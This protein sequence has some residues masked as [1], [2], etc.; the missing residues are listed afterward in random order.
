MLPPQLREPVRNSLEP[1]ASTLRVKL[2]SGRAIPPRRFGGIMARIAAC[3][4][5]AAAV[6]AATVAALKRSW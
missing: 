3:E 1:E 2:A 4:A 6:L 5:E